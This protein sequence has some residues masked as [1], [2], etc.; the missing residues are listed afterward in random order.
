MSNA[1]QHF[2]H[3]TFPIKE[4]ARIS[5]ELATTPQGEI[6]LIVDRDNSLGKYSDILWAS[7]LYCSGFASIVTCPALD[8]INADVL[9][10]LQWYLVT[11]HLSHDAIILVRTSIDLSILLFPLHFL[12]SPPTWRRKSTTTNSPCHFQPTPKRVPDQA[13]R[14]YHLQREQSCRKHLLRIRPLPS[15][16][17]KG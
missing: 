13:S 4:A 5:L 2:P 15:E 7:W 17:Y 3:D 11:D 10:V 16:L 8:Q 9:H 14:L 1:F 6:E 12:T